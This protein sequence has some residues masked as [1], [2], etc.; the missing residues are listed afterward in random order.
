MRPHRPV[1]AAALTSLALAAGSITGTITHATASSAAAGSS[2]STPWMN[3]ALSPARRA[4]LLLSAM[5]LD[6]K[7]AMVHGIGLP[8]AGAGAASVPA[9]TRLGIPALALSDGPLGVGNSATGVTEW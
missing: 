1:V 4:N 6:E 2:A 5:T 3:A 8:L 9:N 7:I